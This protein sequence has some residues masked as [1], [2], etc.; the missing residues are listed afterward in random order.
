M[1]FFRRLR[2][3]ITKLISPN[4]DAERKAKEAKEA[5]KKAEEAAE[6]VREAARKLEEARLK[7]CK[8]INEDNIPKMEKLI[9][10]SKQKLS[11]LKK[12]LKDCEKEYDNK[13]KVNTLSQDLNNNQILYTNLKGTLTTLT[14]TYDLEKCDTTET[15][16]V[17]EN[18]NKLAISQY[19]I[20][21]KL[22]KY[23]QN[24]HEKCIDPYRN[25]C[26]PILR[27]LEK[28]KEY[29]DKNM[30]LLKNVETF[31]TI[32]DN[33]ELTDLLQK[34]QTDNSLF[35]KELKEYKEE[36]VRTD[37]YLQYDDEVCKNILLTTAG[38]VMLYYLFFEI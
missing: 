27:D 18:K 13:C 28:S 32:N 23:K 4:R 14:T 6:K 17:L 36:N 30:T 26:A 16:D 9:A 19:N 3:T 37:N 34:I 21:E 38:S 11:D 25:E 20:S 5:A 24:K 31:A 35:E 33:R 29:I 1:G 7:V 2:R 12:K 8:T 10:A 15:C 22:L